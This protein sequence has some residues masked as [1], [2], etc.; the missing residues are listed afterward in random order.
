MYVL[1]V[2]FY[3]DYGSAALSAYNWATVFEF[4]QQYNKYHLN[5]MNCPVVFMFK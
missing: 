5:H 3:L 4:S 1:L 2:F